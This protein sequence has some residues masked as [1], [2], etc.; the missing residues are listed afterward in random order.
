M[1]ASTTI[2]STRVT[3]GP[4]GQWYWNQGNTGARSSPT[5]PGK[6]FYMGSPY[7]HK[8]GT[9]TFVD[10]T[11]IAGKKSDDGNVWIGGFAAVRMNPGRHEC[12]PSSATTIRNSYEQ[13]VTSY[14]RYLPKR[15]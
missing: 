7:N 10:A 1:D 6:T 3:A 5:N 11:E 8:P 14:R 4:D 13:A 12:G 15:Q 2:A 9:S